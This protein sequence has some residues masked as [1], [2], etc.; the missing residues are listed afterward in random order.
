[1]SKT[2]LLLGSGSRHEKQIY[3]TGGSRDWNNLVT[4]DINPDHNPTVQ[5]DLN[6]HP[7]PFEDDSMDE[8]HAYDV[9]EHLG[10][11][12]DYQYFFKEWTDF[13][14]IL[15]PGGHFCAI[16]PKHDSVWAWADPSHTRVIPMEQL[17]FLSQNTYRE[18]VGKT[19]ISDFRYIYEA[20]FEIVSVSDDAD[21][22]FFVLRAMK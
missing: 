6:D 5:W 17:L 4:V 14:R 7:Y 22:N 8:I 11:Q 21:R 20:D 3:P 13:W 15:K 2:E 12:G 19:A 9:L 16:V 18:Q 10:R 1:M